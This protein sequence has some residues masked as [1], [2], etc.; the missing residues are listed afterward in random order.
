MNRITTI[1]SVSS[2]RLV[3]LVL[4]MWWATVDALQAADNVPDREW[5]GRVESWLRQLGAEAFA[6]RQMAQEQLLSAAVLDPEDVLYRCLHVHDQ[7][8][9]P[10]VSHRAWEI[11]KSVVGKQLL[12]RP[13]GYLGV[14][15]VKVADTQ[16]VGVPLFGMIAVKG[17][18]EGSA[19]A[20]AG[21]QAGDVIL[22]MD[23]MMATP[24]VSLDDFIFNIQSKKPGTMVRLTV[25][26][27]GVARF[28][29]PVLGQ[30][31]DEE[32]VRRFNETDFMERWLKFARLRMNRQGQP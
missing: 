16:M 3:V 8:A 10:E 22:A 9:D 26:R 1:T 18:V 17:V 2:V 14:Q 21:L 24:D 20:D 31:G 28:A 13:R 25:L 30:L 12:P 19:A 11:I 15:L 5:A 7:T 29:F 27:H 6:D 32:L 23:D 4:A